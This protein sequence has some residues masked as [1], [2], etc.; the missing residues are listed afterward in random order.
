LTNSCKAN[1]PAKDICAKAQTAASTAA[2][3]TGAQAD[4]FNAVFG[5]KTVSYSSSLWLVLARLTPMCRN[6]PTFLLLT[7][8]EI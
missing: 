2:A 1:Q 6:S 4:T 8:K 3:K 5:I 7:T